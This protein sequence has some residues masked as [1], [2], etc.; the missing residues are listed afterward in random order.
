LILDKNPHLWIGT[1]LVLD[2]NPLYFFN[3]KS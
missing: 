1:G 3:H 2:W